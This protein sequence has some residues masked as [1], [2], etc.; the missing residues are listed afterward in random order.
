MLELHYKLLCTRC[1]ILVVWCTGSVSSPHW[2]PASLEPFDAGGSDQYAA[3]GESGIP[4]VHP[5]CHPEIVSNVGCH[6]V[7]LIA[8]SLILDSLEDMELLL[9]TG[10]ENI[11]S[12]DLLND[13][14][15][16]AVL[17]IFD[18]ISSANFS[19]GKVPVAEGGE[20]S[21]DVLDLVL[22]ALESH[23]TS[24]GILKHLEQLRFLISQPHFQVNRSPSLHLPSDEHFRLLVSKV[25]FEFDGDKKF[26]SS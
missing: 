16:S 2:T 22:D 13:R 9:S 20:V 25:Q 6:G 23:E 14:S 19:Y 4:G 12:P 11:V 10:R 17:R 8:V 18:M 26:N 15:L 5:F 24:D 3:S 1:Y 21:R 7:G